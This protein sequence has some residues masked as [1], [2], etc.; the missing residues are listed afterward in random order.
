[1]KEVCVNCGSDTTPEYYCR[2][3]GL[4]VQVKEVREEWTLRV[5][6]EVYVRGEDK[7]GAQSILD[8]LVEEITRLDVGDAHQLSI[9]EESLEDN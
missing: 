9:V 7:E 5:T 6:V 2:T 8:E 4:Y 1:M 3:C